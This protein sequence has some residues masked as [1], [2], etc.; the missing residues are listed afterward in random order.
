[1]KQKTHHVIAPSILLNAYIALRTLRTIRIT[2]TYELVDIKQ[3][4]QVLNCLR[5]F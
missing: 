4:L 3:K 5:I 1:M 2:K